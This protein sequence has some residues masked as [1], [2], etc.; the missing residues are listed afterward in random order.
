MSKSLLKEN[1]RRMRGAQF[2]ETLKILLK[3]N[4]F[5]VG[6]IFIERGLSLSCGLSCKNGE[7]FP[8]MRA[9]RIPKLR[10]TLRE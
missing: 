5:N 3:E 10:I 8:E 1:L 4:L 7:R 6:K 2:L 9:P